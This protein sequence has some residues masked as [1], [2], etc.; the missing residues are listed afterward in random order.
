M[1]AL[2]DLMQAYFGGGNITDAQVAFYAAAAAGG[3]TGGSAFAIG[4]GLVSSG[5]ES[6]PRA[7][8]ISSVATGSGHLRFTYFTCPK[9]FTAT[10]LSAYSTGTPAAATPTLV[11]YGLYTVASNGDLTLV[12]STTNDTAVFSVASTQYTRAISGPSAIT[13]YAM[14]TGQR[15]AFGVLIVTGVATPTMWGWQTPLGAIANLEP[16]LGSCLTG[17]AD[18]PASITSASLS[19]AQAAFPA[20]LILP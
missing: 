5:V 9:S 1:P 8:A 2:N 3:V 7:L 19:N 6:F 16:K 13:S 20:G 11:R 14:V 18:L 4:S 10:Q 12:A 17:Q 15:Y